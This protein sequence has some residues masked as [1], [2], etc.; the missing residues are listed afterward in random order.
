[1]VLVDAY[2]NNYKQFKSTIKDD[3][4]WAGV[5]Y[6]LNSMGLDSAMRVGIGYTLLRKYVK[7]AMKRS[8]DG[9]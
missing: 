3:L 8:L 6:S 1:M 9:E 2:L 7:P 4:L 5:G